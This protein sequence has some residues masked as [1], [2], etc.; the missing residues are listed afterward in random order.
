MCLPIATSNYTPALVA[1]EAAD[2]GAS[3][4]IRCFITP[5][6]FCLDPVL[7]S[8]RLADVTL[9][10]RALRGELSASV[11][12]L[13]MGLYNTLDISTESRN[14]AP[15]PARILEDTALCLM[16][17]AGGDQVEDPLEKW[18]RE[19]VIPVDLE[20]LAKAASTTEV[21]Q[22]AL[23]Y[24]LDHPSTLRSRLTQS[25]F[26]QRRSST[27]RYWAAIFTGDDGVPAE[28]AVGIRA[29]QAPP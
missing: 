29:P 25:G 26:I 14:I 11:M 21:V 24:Y 27:Q 3:T 23:L 6:R 10:D 15:R 18:R 20:N 28:K 1:N 9:G 12:W 17:D 19:A 7:P 2:S 4:R 8:E 16:R 22:S 13:A 5:H